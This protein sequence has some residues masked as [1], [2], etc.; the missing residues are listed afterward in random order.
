[1]PGLSALVAASL[2]LVA[3]RHVNEPGEVTAK[4]KAR[5]RARAKVANEERSVEGMSKAVSPDKC[6]DSSPRVIRQK[7][8]QLVL[9]KQQS[10]QQGRCQGWTS[11]LFIL[12]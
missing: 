5:T 6:Q 2:A 11:T 4:R 8:G 7:V 3:A 1:M 9:I 10:V 12:M